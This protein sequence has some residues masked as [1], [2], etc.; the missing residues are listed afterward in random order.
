METLA[1]GTS[2]GTITL[3]WELTCHFQGMARKPVWMEKR[4]GGGGRRHL[5]GRAR[6]D[7]VIG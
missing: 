6:Q 2:A 3:R 4:E 7:Q 5:C 1:E